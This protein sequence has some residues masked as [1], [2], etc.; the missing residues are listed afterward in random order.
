MFPY[1]SGEGLHVGHMKGYSYSDTIARKKKMEGY[2]VLHP[3]GWDAFGLPA[4]NFALKHGIHPGESTEKNIANIKKQLQSAGFMYDWDRE[5]NSSS[6]E[7]YK[8]TQWLFL[9]LYKKG[10]AYRKEAPVNFCPSC[11]ASLANEEVVD[12]KCERCGTI[13]IK[14]I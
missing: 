3:M 5:I 9:Q 2:N 12:G 7:Y 11:K 14:K 10:L 8:W 6:S 1:P 13:T 4:E